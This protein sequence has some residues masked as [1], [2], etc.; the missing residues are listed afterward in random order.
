MF[1]RFLHILSLMVV[2]SGLSAYTAFAQNRT[3]T[4]SVADAA[5]VPVMGVA[6]IQQGTSNGVVT[7]LDG[8]FT[9]QVKGT[10]DVTL[11]VTSMGYKT[12][13]ITVPASQQSV[14]ITIY[15]DS[16]MLEETIVVGYGTQKKVN[17]TGAVTPV[18]AKELEGRSAHN[19]NVT[20]FKI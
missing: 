14:K 6:I 1:K 7:D 19:K 16:E 9:I 12:Q 11:Q 15:E 10:G 20:F 8:L 5:G 3:I 4:G 18:D 13:T 2:L 17:L